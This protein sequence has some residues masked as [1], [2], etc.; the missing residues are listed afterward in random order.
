MILLKV[1]R[2][3]EE[4]ISVTRFTI[5]E[6]KIMLVRNFEI[7]NDYLDIDDQN[8][9][10]IKGNRVK[11]SGWFNDYRG[12]LSCVYVKDQRLFYLSNTKD[13]EIEEVF[14]VSLDKVEDENVIVIQDENQV[15]VESYMY[16]VD[17]IDFSDFE[18]REDWGMFI[19]ELITNSNRRQ[20][21]IEVMTA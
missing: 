5:K 10:S 16:K 7:F 8:R 1:H 11:I 18:P 2:E 20:T 13:F 3:Q 15:I 6:H 4:R 19:C 14:T 12:S 17:N 9:L 21:F